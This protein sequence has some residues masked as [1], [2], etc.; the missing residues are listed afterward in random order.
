MFLNVSIDNLFRFGKT[1]TPLSTQSF[2]RAD[3]S[4]PFDLSDDI[5]R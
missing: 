1:N 4:I 3:L 5:S 2:D